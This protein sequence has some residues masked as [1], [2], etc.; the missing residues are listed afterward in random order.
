MKRMAFVARSVTA[1]VC[2]A[3]GVAQAEPDVFQNMS[4]GFDESVWDIRAGAV[5]LNRSGPVLSAPPTTSVSNVSDFDWIGGPDIQIARRFNDTD[6]IEVRYFSA[7]GWSAEFDYADPVLSFNGTYDA[8]LFSTEVNVRRQHSDRIAFLAGFRTL[9][10]HELMN[11][12]DRFSSFAFATRTAN[13]LYGAQ[14]GVDAVLRDR[15]GPFRI[16]GNAKAGIYGTVAQAHYTN[17]AGFNQAANDSL[18]SFVGDMAF[19]AV[20]QFTD[21]L[22][23]RAGYQLLWIE[24]LALA[25]DQLQFSQDVPPLP[26]DTL[27]GMF[28]HGALVGFEL[29]W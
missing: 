21:R 8:S 5:I 10:L 16:E 27:G 26:L 3:V 29:T 6:S 19:T 24:G 20:Y 1:A 9:E 11:N 18:V 12:A 13:Y 25:G 4:L 22:A 7:I 23:F 15:G 14:A 2:M 17:T 28:A